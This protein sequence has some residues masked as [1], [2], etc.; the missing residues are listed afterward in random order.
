CSVCRVASLIE[1]CNT[2]LWLLSAWRWLVVSSGEVLPEFFSVGSGGKLFAV[3]LNGVFVISG[4]G[5]SQEYSVFASGHRCVASVVQSVSLVELH[6]VFSAVLV[7][8]VCPQG[9]GGLLRFL[10]PGVL[11]QMVVW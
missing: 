5:S 10:T 7:D 2:C 9:A 1:C 3:V 11:S 6:S 8:F 4:G